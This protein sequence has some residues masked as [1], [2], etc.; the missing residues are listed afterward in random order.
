MSLRKSHFWRW[1][2]IYFFLLLHRCKTYFD[3]RASV[4]I[5]PLHGKTF[6]RRHFIGKRLDD[7][8]IPETIGLLYLGR[9]SPSCPPI[10]T[11]F[12]LGTRC[13]VVQV[14]ANRSTLPLYLV[15]F[16]SFYESPSYFSQ[17]V[18]DESLPTSIQTM[19]CKLLL[20]LVECIKARSEKE[21]CINKGRELLMR[22]NEVF[23]LK[24]KTVAKMQLPVL[25]A[26]HKQAFQQV[27]MI[28]I[29]LYKNF[30]FKTKNEWPIPR[31]HFLNY[32]IWVVP[33]FYLFTLLL[34]WW[35]SSNQMLGKENYNWIKNTKM[36]K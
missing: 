2:F 33:A 5:C 10:F 19:S 3:N 30:F 17:N 25:M 16:D 28:H 23:V 35:N 24:F 34:C 1:N 12:W 13:S 6:R 7:T 4:K 36:L 31:N 15:P 32:T 27:L 14:C 9:F 29:L 18:H 8:R 20:N 21:N 22:M 26:K 11:P